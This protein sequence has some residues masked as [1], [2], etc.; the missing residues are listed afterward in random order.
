L[1]ELANQTEGAFL[2][3]P[4]APNSL[5]PLYGTVG[6]LLSLALPTYRLTFNVRAD[7]ANVFVSGNALLVTSRWTRAQ[8]RSMLPFI[9]GV[10]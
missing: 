10:P 9:V 8:L 4:T 7:A 3:A 1:A 2:F 6:D 5:I